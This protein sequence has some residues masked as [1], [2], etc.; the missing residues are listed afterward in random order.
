MGIP[1]DVCPMS[2]TEENH[3]REDNDNEGDLTDFHAHVEEQ[4]GPRDVVIRQSYHCKPRED[5]RALEHL[6][7][8]G[9]IC[10]LPTMTVER[11]RQGRKVEIRE[12]LLAG[13]PLHLLARQSFCV[14]HHGQRIAGQRIG[15][16][17]IHQLEAPFHGEAPSV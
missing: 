13:E 2:L 5:A 6:T 7:R 17:Y 14:M 11:W 9:F 15:M 12:P 8:Q 16:K 1:R 4:Q 3:Q 10:Y